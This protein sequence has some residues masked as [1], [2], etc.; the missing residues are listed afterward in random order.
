MHADIYLAFLSADITQS[1]FDTV[2]RLLWGMITYR[3][4][5]KSEPK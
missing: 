2:G 3:K 1:Y 5:K 4:D